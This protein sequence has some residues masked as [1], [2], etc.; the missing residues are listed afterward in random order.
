[1]VDF[2][3]PELYR[4]QLWHNGVQ[5]QESSTYPN[6]STSDNLHFSY[7][8]ST[9]EISFVLE[10]ETAPEVEIHQLLAVRLTARLDLD[11]DFFDD[12]AQNAFINNIAI[13]LNIDPAR[14]R[15]VEI[16][17]GSVVVQT[18]IEDAYADDG[19]YNGTESAL[20]LQELKD[21]LWTIINATDNTSTCS[22]CNVT[23]ADLGA[24][25]MSIDA[26]WVPKVY[27]YENTTENTTENTENTGNT[28]NGS[29]TDTTTDATTDG[30]TDSVITG[31]SQ[32]FTEAQGGG[33]TL[34]W[35]LVG[36]G[37]AVFLAVVIFSILKL[38]RTK[39]DSKSVSKVHPQIED[40]SDDDDNEV[41]GMAPGISR[42]SS[43]VPVDSP[44][45]L[46]RNKTL[47]PLLRIQSFALSSKNLKAD[48][49]SLPAK[50]AGSGDN[51]EEKQRKAGEEARLKVQADE[52]A[53][54]KAQADEEARLKAQAEAEAKAEAA[55]AQAKAEAAEAQAILEE[56]R[57]EQ[58][59]INTP[60]EQKIE[61]YAQFIG[62]MEA[63]ERAAS[64]PMRLFANSRTLLQQETFRKS[65]WPKL[66]V[67]QEEL[68][69]VFLAYEAK[70]SKRFVYNGRDAHAD[71]EYD[72]DVRFATNHLSVDQYAGNGTEPILPDKPAKSPKLF[73]LSQRR[74]SLSTRDPASPS[75][76][77]GSITKS[78][79]GKGG[80]F[81]E[82]KQNR[83]VLPTLAP[84]KN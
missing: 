32:S 62:T 18:D 34:Q 22:D 64:D 15:I 70:Y 4:L 14:V 20:A 65:Q 5:M 1:V 44:L 73:N 45:H 49:S 81:F 25:V 39:K 51:A 80:R 58:E 66:Q 60:I 82:G 10:C 40:S 28:S 6:I 56:N 67:K 16:T 9:R 21:A 31:S 83:T 47:P 53:R 74:G 72:M 27:V 30:N 29:T 77:R 41:V 68:L 36:V 59:A 12:T 55:E 43:Q 24:E 13:M 84:A 78:P 50:A 69:K 71:L 79:T 61:R 3:Y 37:A 57:R 52:E 19:T 8:K 75:R 76:R 26:P 33:D 17:A 2:F 35:A 42:S 48:Y 38:T 7:N 46:T 11:L 63:Y 23:W 54:L